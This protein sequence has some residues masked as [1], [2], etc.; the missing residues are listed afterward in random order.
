MNKTKK[1]IC[2]IL[3]LIMALS[4]FA[5]PASAAGSLRGIR[6]F[7]L[8]GFGEERFSV[9]WWKNE[10]NGK[11]YVF[12]PSDADLSAMTPVFDA[13]F[14]VYAG[15]KKIVSGEKTD[16]FANVGEYTLTC[17]SSRYKLI[18]M[19]SANVPA[20]Y[21]ET[22]SGSLDYIHADKS[23][24]EEGKIAVIQDGEVI[25]D[26]ELSSIKG[27]GNSTWAWP[28]K[29]YNIKFDK[30]TDL[31]GMG[32]A[33]KW[34]LLASYNDAA[35]V[36]NKVVF[37][38]ADD[39]G[40]MYSS[41]SQHV[42]LYINGEYMGNYLV[43][44]SVE[45]GSTRVDI[46][47]LD[48]A[49]EN[50]NIG[51]DIEEFAQMG[52]IKG[53]TD[54]MKWVDIPKDPADITGGYLIE[55]ELYNRYEAEV[56][57]F[58]TKGGQ[59]V[60][61]KSPEYASKAQ[62]E[63]ISGFYSEFEE[64]AFSETGYNS[65]GKHYSDYID[66]DSAVK[67]YL[68][69]E[70][71]MDVDAGRASAYFYKEAGEN[72]KLVASPVWDFDF[73]LGNGMSRSGVKS[74]DP[75]IWYALN[76]HNRATE[77]P[78]GDT[79][80]SIFTA[81]MKQDDFFGK[82]CSEW[83]GTFRALAEEY[84]VKTHALTKE[85]NASA[86][87]NSA[88][89]AKTADDVADTQKYYDAKVNIVTDFTHKRIDTLDKGFS[90][91]SARLYFDV[92][93]GSGMHNNYTVAVAGESVKIESAEYLTAPEGMSFLEWNTKPDGSGTS[94]KTGDEIVLE[95]GK[96]VLYA[97]WTESKLLGLFSRVFSGFTAF[98]Q[99]IIELFK[100]LITLE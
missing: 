49:N 24:K 76:S 60:V 72:T 5:L 97:Q 14:D 30:K 71:T 18:I 61:V 8:N 12:L 44:E 92:N 43:C 95:K 64:A 70:F 17:T 74:S 98:I 36:R 66:I 67:M 100:S 38:M 37:D 3:T 90:E 75:T 20:M 59:P 6:S 41:K 26:A 45:V 82:V 99:R 55:M 22:E 11:Y 23:N 39:L 73:A 58:I 21:I 54:S 56:S 40:L 46:N 4:V 86:L 28:K 88:R 78:T 50:A 15:S 25:V 48:E 96:T 29:P 35:L 31:F 9:S 62:V 69:E 84:Q 1:I 47:D 68:I 42:D 85:L 89:W 83:Q 32:K 79:V 53:S 87:M 77:S 52:D 2:V 7:S 10:L 81:L 16:V 19:K 91:N 51:A 13:S 65:L 93:G 57:G 63:Y 34:S 80:Y 27:R 94:Y 33:K